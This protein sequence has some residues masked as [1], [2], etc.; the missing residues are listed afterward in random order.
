MYTAVARVPV[1]PV[2]GVRSQGTSGQVSDIPVASQDI[3]SSDGMYRDGTC[4]WDF[5][6]DWSQKHPRIRMGRLVV[7]ADGT[8]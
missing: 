7:P 5:S 8:S 6:L 2:T 4:P 1:T 3:P